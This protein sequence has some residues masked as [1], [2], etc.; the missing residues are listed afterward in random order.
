MAT[1]NQDIQGSASVSRDLNVGG[2]A[3][4]RG[5][6]NIDHDLSVKGILYAGDIMGANKGLFKDIESLRQA[7]PH[8]E[9]GQYAYVGEEFPAE[10][11][12]SEGGEWKNSGTT[13]YGGL[14]SAD[15]KKLESLRDWNLIGV[16]ALEDLDKCGE[17][18]IAYY[19]L[20]GKQRPS[21]R[22]LVTSE[23][24]GGDGR[25]VVGTLD[26]IGDNM[27]H[28]ITQIFTTHL[29]YY[30]DTGF[31]MGAHT[32]TIVY[33]YFRS[34]GGFGGGN[35]PA[36]QW[37]PWQDITPEASEKNAGLLSVKDYKALQK[38]IEN[39]PLTVAINMELTD[40]ARQEGTYS[41]SSLMIVD[42][43]QK[44]SFFELCKNWNDE[45]Q[46]TFVFRINGVSYHVKPVSFNL[47]NA[48]ECHFFIVMPATAWEE[49]GS[50][51]AFSIIVDLNYQ[52][53]F[54]SEIQT[55]Q[56]REIAVKL[57]RYPMITDDM[58]TDGNAYLL[59]NGQLVPM[60]GDNTKELKENSDGKGTEI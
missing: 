27:M 39:A 56:P 31:S 25:A 46:L 4:I 33:Q 6:V 7:Y 23:M 58:R 36:N 11:W 60:F 42:E 59:V 55:I 15:R 16:I 26:I 30:K 47:V 54:T 52:R 41:P 19:G 9:P 49:G 40:D 3:Q 35:L 24:A 50:Y 57:A 32:D 8:P 1:G 37:T 5:G 10:L 28:Q 2:D 53:L 12:M 17:D 18:F 22:L 13:G 29:N 21:M 14:D 43:E 44:R 48:Q 20:G 34:W 51:W 38:L 45:K